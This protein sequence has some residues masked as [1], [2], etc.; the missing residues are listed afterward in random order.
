VFETFVKFK[1]LVEN[2]F[3]LKIKQVQT[4]GGGEYT[5]NKFLSFL[6]TNGILHRLTCPHTSQ[7][8][9]I[10]ERKH[11]HVIETALSLLAHSH[12][13]SKYWVEAV[14][15]SVYLINRLPTP[16]LKNFSPFLKLFQKAPDYTLLKTFGCACY[17]LLKPYTKHKLEFR[18]KQ[19]VFLGYSSNQKGY[20]C[21]DPTSN[22]IYVSIHVVFDEVLFPAQGGSTTTT[23]AKVDF[24]KS[25]IVLDPSHFTSIHASSQ[26][27]D[28]VDIPPD[29]QTDTPHQSFVND[30]TV[31][32]PFTP[33]PD[34]TPPTSSLND[35]NFSQ[36]ASPNT[37]S[38]DHSS[39]SMSHS[40]ELPLA[41]TSQ[42]DPVVPSTDA[43]LLQALSTSPEPPSPHMVTRSM[44][45]LSKPKNFP[46][47]KLYHSLKSTKHPLKAMASFT[48]PPIPTTFAKAAIIPHWFAA[49][50]SEIQALHDNGT[51][52]LCPRPSNCNIIKNK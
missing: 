39:S 12:L 14:S 13:P 25:G 20:K 43:S 23:P 17:P 18:S 26:S 1:C 38:P 15:T 40:D 8:N 21:L 36:A 30:H 51:W 47:Y 24:L 29:I 35:S 10:A 48:H 34:N 16:T 28:N 52:S 6:S 31:V 22:R 49:M 27:L 7:Q 9:G 2:Y 3:N 32:I 46:D 5:S 37:Q 33:F 4:D 11:R 41:L 45:G 42:P 19:C 50:E 44:T